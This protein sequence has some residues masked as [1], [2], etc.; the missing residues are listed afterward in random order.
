M[1]SYRSLNRQARNRVKVTC[2]C[3]R[4]IEQQFFSHHS[5]PIDPR[6][7][8]LSLAFELFQA[9]KME[10]PCSSRTCP[11]GFGPLFTTTEI[12]TAPTSLVFTCDRRTD[13]ADPVRLAPQLWMETANSIAVSPVCA[14]VS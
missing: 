8:Y 7:D 6:C 11:V 4:N 13:V 3:C 2:G 5:L 1:L 10:G 9:S 14:V 12:L